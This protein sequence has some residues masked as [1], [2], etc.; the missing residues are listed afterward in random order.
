[1]SDAPGI[2]L[3]L[4]DGEREL[5]I[6]AVA[7]LA[8]ADASGQFGLQPGHEP[9]VTVLEPGLWRY[10]TVGQDG[11]TFGASVG[12]LLACQRAGGGTE[13]RIVSRRLLL[14]A[15]PEALQRRLDAL[16]EREGH[17]LISVRQ[18]QQ[19]LDLALVKRLQQLAQTSP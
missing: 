3:V 7:S 16:R 14:D 5:R 12:G 4:L 18:N 11:W 19:H 10:R 8:A 13:V 2:G 17:L 1:M 15:E 9:L 6:D